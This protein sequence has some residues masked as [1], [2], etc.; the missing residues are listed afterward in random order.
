[1]SLPAYAAIDPAIV[2]FVGKLKPWDGVYA[3]WGRAEF[4]PYVEMAKALHGAD[5]AWR[6]QPPL[7][8]FA[9]HFKPLVRRDD[10]ADIA[11]RD[12]VDRSVRQHSGHAPRQRA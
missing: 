11:Y 9:Y 6:R 10:Y 5:V 4:E 3:P 1:M 7:R 12:A 2:H 8:R